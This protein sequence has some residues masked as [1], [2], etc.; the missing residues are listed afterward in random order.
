ML[1]PEFRDE[2]FSQSPEGILM[3]T[4]FDDCIAVYPMPEWQLIEQ[5]F[6]SLNMANR[7]FRDFHRFF[8]SGAVEVTLDKQGRVL[9]PPHLRSYAGLHKD[10][11]LAGV[12]RKFEIWDLERFEAQRKTMQDDF[13]QVMDD[14][15][16][17]GF[18]LRF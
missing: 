18:E 7:K 1:P 13:D 5:S 10:I 17:N 9:I 8:I 12:G 11:V 6:A 2:V 4:N 14:L 3:M 16:E 15:A